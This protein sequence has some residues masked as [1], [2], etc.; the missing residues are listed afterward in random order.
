MK[1]RFCLKS[2]QIIKL[3]INE[4]RK[5]AKKNTKFTDHSRIEMLNDRITV[6]EI[7]EAI[8]SGE[9]TEQYTGDKPFPSCLVYGRANNRHIHIVCALP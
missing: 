6:D 7:F 9:I 5:R 2:K 1:F 3:N 8:D 4:I